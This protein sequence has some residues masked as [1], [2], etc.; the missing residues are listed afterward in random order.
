MASEVLEH[1]FL[2]FLRFQGSL[3][4][5]LEKLIQ[6][7][8]PKPPFPSDGRL[9]NKTENWQSL[10]VTI[11][12]DQ[13][14]LPGKAKKRRL[15]SNVI[16][17]AMSAAGD[18]DRHDTRELFPM[19]RPMVAAATENS[20]HS[21][22][23]L[24]DETHRILDLVAKNAHST[25]LK[26]DD[27][28]GSRTSERHS[29]ASNR[30]ESRRSRESEQKKDALLRS[31]WVRHIA[32]RSNSLCSPNS[33]IRRKPVSDLPGSSARAPPR[34]PAS[35]I[36]WGDFEHHGF[37]ETTNS[38]D[39]FLNLEFSRNS[40]DIEA[41]PD[42]PNK[43]KKPRSGSYSSKP[44]RT[45][46]LP[47]SEHAEAVY[48]VTSPTYA[49]IQ[50]KEL[51]SRK[52]D[53]PFFELY[54]DTLQD[55]QATATWP[56][57]T[58]VELKDISG[59][60]KGLIIEEQEADYVLDDSISSGSLDA[61]KP[62][63]RLTPPDQDITHE[64]PPEKGKPRTLS[65]RRRSQRRISDVFGRLS[66]TGS[67]TN[68][69]T[70]SEASENSPTAIS[71]P[72]RIPAV[73]TS[74]NKHREPP[75]FPLQSERPPMPIIVKT[76]PLTPPRY[77]SVPYPQLDSSAAPKLSPIAAYKARSLPSPP[78][79]PAEARP[80]D[81]TDRG[82]GALDNVENEAFT[83]PLADNDQQV[84]LLVDG[85]EH[86]KEAE[87]DV[88]S[89]A[90]TIKPADVSRSLPD[91]AS[92]SEPEQIP[93]AESNIEANIADDS[94]HSETELGG[95]ASEPADQD[96]SERT[97]LQAAPVTRGLHQVTYPAASAVNPARVVL[98]ES[99]KSG[100]PS[101][102]VSGNQS[103]ED[104]NVDTPIGGLSENK[105]ENRHVGT[106]ATDT[107]ASPSEKLIINSNKPKFASTLA[108]AEEQREV[109]TSA[110]ELDVEDDMA[111]IESGVAEKDQ[112]A[113]SDPNPSFKHNDA[114]RKSL[115]RDIDK[116][117]SARKKSLS[118]ISRTDLQAGIAGVPE[119]ATK[120][121]SDNQLENTAAPP[122][123]FRAANDPAT[124]PSERRFGE[125]FN[126]VSPSLKARIDGIAGTTK[127]VSFASNP[128]AATS[129]SRS[130]PNK[131]QAL[132]KNLTNPI[133]PSKGATLLM[134][135]KKGLGKKKSMRP[136]VPQEETLS[137]TSSL[138]L[139]TPAYSNHIIEG[140]SRSAEQVT[141]IRR[142][143]DADK[144]APEPPMPLKMVAKKAAE[145][146]TVSTAATEES[147]THQSKVAQIA[148]QKITPATDLLEPDY[149]QSAKKQP[150]LDDKGEL[151][152]YRVR[153]EHT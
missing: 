141:D 6:R 79:L 40:S 10:H 73:S 91:T 104:R 111:S 137:N 69:A 83:Q 66:N 47:V 57:F 37:M 96:I 92:P 3:P 80:T 38:E 19:W 49:S 130:P 32:A 39:V 107:P 78:P 118:S 5:R 17:T 25:F 8:P 147:D 121:P 110:S 144:V 142:P 103:K 143:R 148:S 71:G 101:S 35:R 52:I 126:R 2:C 30:R 11:H 99:E 131:T 16:K 95:S 124:S 65:L 56:V 13:R 54:L 34:N 31:Q 29:T 48:E 150:Y 77:T 138:P 140:S 72:L 113:D 100:S 122:E 14:S 18:H 59:P 70:T 128:P 153:Q 94:D 15:P 93:L 4:G 58:I 22:N 127:L 50:L 33:T 21:L 114:T 64:E 105:L 36:S 55:L 149:S 132:P 45:S 120:A 115:D 76:S 1:I 53:R 62:S 119:S 97:G 135:A 152:R 20:A 82:D 75:T 61:R 27:I 123:T 109:E 44:R 74:A 116:A 85:R 88:P 60:Y 151:M 129:Q 7:Y 9:V 90:S 102:G 28:H 125:M 67:T 84:P 68:L 136:D 43:L 46:P 112:D 117:A 145:R 26:Q 63:S 12:L 146:S 41:A 108:I 139:Q 89:S 24:S 106:R 86:R 87:Q 51:E 134:G 133:S 42:K 98:Q 81:I 23:I